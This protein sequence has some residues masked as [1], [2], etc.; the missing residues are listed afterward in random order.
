MEKD[1]IIRVEKL[2]VN[3]GD[4][5]DLS[6]VLLVDDGKKRSVGTPTVKGASVQAEVVEQD[7]DKKVTIFKKK[8]R[9]N[10]RRK[11]GHRQAKTVLKIT[12]IKAA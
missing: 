9:Q 7:R 12:D 1:T 8:K 10:Y 5:I 4:K 6:E 11:N 3:K 2:D